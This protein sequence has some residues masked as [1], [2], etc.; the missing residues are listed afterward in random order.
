VAIWDNGEIQ[1]FGRID[2][3]VKIRG[4][5]IELGAIEE[6]LNEQDRVKESLVIA[7]EDRPGDQRLVAYV[8]PETEDSIPNSAQI[9]SWKQGIK[10]LLPPYMIPGDFVILSKFPL[11]P[12]GKIDRKELP[13]P[14]E[15]LL[16]NK[17]QALPKTETEKLIA[18]VW[19]AVL[20]IE[21]LG[22]ND[23]FF[24]LGGHSLLAVQVMTRLEKETGV[25]LPITTLFKISGLADFAKQFDLAKGRVADSEQKII[26]NSQKDSINNPPDSPIG[27]VPPR[28]DIESL[29][30]Q[31]W[32]EN[33]GLDAVGVYDD[34]FE[35]GGHSM[36]AI[37]VLN[38]LERET[39][40]RLPLASLFEHSTVES[41]AM[42]LEMD[43]KLITWD[44]TKCH[45]TLFMV[46]D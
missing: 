16:E 17:N 30:A 37:Q 35:L 28:T 11:L 8:I 27:Y 10:E 21:S 4:Y 34:F 29:V 19:K 25:K 36:M 18:E 6:A 9:A 32:A 26:S 15:S 20:E 12:N 38:Q 23:D 14:N 44:S 33:L 24:D 40:K 5:R 2:N 3:Q 46:P 7:R 13:K 39:G 1:C 43:A 22:L 45:F 41:M 31:I 42:M